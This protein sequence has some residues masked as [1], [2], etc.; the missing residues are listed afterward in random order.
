MQNGYD[1]NQIWASSPIIL[2]WRKSTGPTHLSEGQMSQKCKHLDLTKE[3]THVWDDLPFSL[4]TP[5]SCIQTLFACLACSIFWLPSQATFWLQGDWE[6]QFW[7][8]EKA[9][10]P[11]MWVAYNR[12]RRIITLTGSF[13]LFL[14]PSMGPFSHLSSRFGGST[15]ALHRVWPFHKPDHRG[16]SCVATPSYSFWPGGRRM[17]VGHILK[18]FL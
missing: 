14:G 6:G 12:A 7:H 3:S 17:G 18:P 11:W 2:K 1:R 16:S 5:W 15:E 4:S 8:S 10:S 9:S 13:S